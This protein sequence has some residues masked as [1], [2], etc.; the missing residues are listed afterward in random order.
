MQTN[1]R[2]NPRH[3]ALVAAMG[4]SYALGTFADNFFKQCLVLIAAYAGATGTHALV[5]ESGADAESLATTVQ[6]I[7]TVLYSLPFIVCS[8]WAGWLA[9]RCVKK[10]IILCAKLT[11]F[12]SLFFGAYALLTGWWAGMLLVVFCMGLQSTFFS[13]NCR[14]FAR[15]CLCWLHT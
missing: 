5:A 13:I 14:Y 4:G 10:H 12:I 6:S 8:A 3:G 2:E 15:H 11:E 9:D 7:A 1:E